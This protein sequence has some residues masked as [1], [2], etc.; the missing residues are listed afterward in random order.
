MIGTHADLFPILSSIGW[1]V[2]L[3]L[4]GWWVFTRME[5]RFADWV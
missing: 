2:A 5:V 4:V 3:V 1:T